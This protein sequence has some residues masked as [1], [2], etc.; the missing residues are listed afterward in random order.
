MAARAPV[1]V[2]I[3]IP[4][5]VAG[6]SAYEGL[7]PE[8]GAADSHDMRIEKLSFDDVR[9]SSVLTRWCARMG[10]NRFFVRIAYI[11]SLVRRLSRATILHLVH[12]SHVSGR[13]WP[14]LL[15]LIGRFF[16]RKVILDY[17]SPLTLSRLAGRSILVRKIWRLCDLVLVPSKYQ[18]QLVDMLGG[19][20][21]YQNPRFIPSEVTARVVTK[22]QPR[23]VV[24]ADLEPEHNVA[25]AVRAYKLVKQKYPRTEMVIVGSGSQRRALEH[26][27]GGEKGVGVS[28]A[29]ELGR[30]ERRR[31]FETSEVYVNCSM[32]N[33]L[34]GA[35]L[36]AL[37]HGLPVLTTPLGGGLGMFRDHDNV[38][39][40]SYS[41]SVALAERIIEL[42]EDSKLV[43][44]LSKRS[45]ETALALEQDISGHIAQELYRELSGS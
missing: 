24:A 27:A 29:G 7:V 36:E 19:K 5:R 37:A 34:S 31:L 8:H 20:A 9:V 15:I 16:G 33:F 21:R 43:E 40:L 18:E 6:K 26:L 42:V 3:A 32:V 30:T 39:Q 14:I 44:R 38:I 13:G 10:M 17:A 35:T 4:D 11:R 12:P 23:L 1:E 45:R 22:I 25:S 28:F 2:V 41:N